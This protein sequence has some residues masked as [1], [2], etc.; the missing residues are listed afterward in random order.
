MTATTAISAQSHAPWLGSQGY[1]ALV[2]LDTDYFLSCRLVLDLA[3]IPTSAGY[4]PDVTAKDLA[5]FDAVIHLAALSNDPIGNL[6]SAW[7]RDINGAGHSPPGR[8]REAAGVRVRFSPPHASC[9]ARRKHSAVDDKPRASGLEDPRH[10]L[11]Q[12]SKRRLRCVSSPTIASLQCFCRNGAPSSWP[13]CRACASIHIL[14]NLMGSAFTTRRVMLH[15]DGTPWRPV[16]HVQDVARAFSGR[17]RGATGDRP[18]PGFQRRR[19]R[20]QPSNRRATGRL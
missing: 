11:V 15:S 8:T 10:M 16:V 19:G 2:G 6:N 20:A 9:M 13:L 3:P 7:T 12:R 5:G 14:N 18:Q 1:D 4:P 17:R